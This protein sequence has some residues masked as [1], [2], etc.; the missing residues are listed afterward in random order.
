MD[1]CSKW[2]GCVDWL[3][4][5][6][7]VQLLGSWPSLSFS[8]DPYGILVMTLLGPSVRSNK[9]RK[10][11]SSSCNS[12]DEPSTQ[13][14]K[15]QA[16]ARPVWCTCGIKS[17]VKWPYR[18]MPKLFSLSTWLRV[19]LRVPQ[20]KKWNTIMVAIA[21]S[22]HQIA[23]LLGKIIGPVFLLDKAGFTPLGYMTT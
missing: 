9:Q 13:P 8:Y 15:W 3:D 5:E 12:L 10:S 17:A 4:E 1:I 19:Q 20:H 18:S 22:W 14:E 2:M 21:K 16:W 7:H 11:N 6:S 23:P